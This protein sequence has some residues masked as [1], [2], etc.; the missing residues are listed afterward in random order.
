MGARGPAKGSGGRP[1]SKSP[2]ANDAGYKLTTVGPKSAGKRELEHRVI[3]FGGKVG[4]TKVPPASSKTAT[5]GIVNHKDM[6]RSDDRKANLEI[7]TR[8]VNNL[9]KYR[10]KR[11]KR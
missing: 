2:A 3:A 11:A 5:T 6:K 10:T 8:S 9:G 4:G 7:T 1:R